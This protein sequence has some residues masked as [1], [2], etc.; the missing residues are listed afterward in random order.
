M[1][2]GLRG[3]VAIAMVLAASVAHGSNQWILGSNYGTITPG[4]IVNAYANT[5]G[6]DND[7]NIANNASLQTIETALWN[8]GYGGVKNQDAPGTSAGTHNVNGTGT[9]EG[10][11]SN[12]RWRSS[13]CDA[14]EG[15][16]PEHAIDNNQRYDMVLLS[17]AAPVRLE[18]VKLGWMQ[19][20]SD[21]TVMAFDKNRTF[22]SLI[23]NTFG[24]LLSSGWQ[25]VG[26]YFNVGTTNA[27]TVNG[28]GIASSYWLIGAYNPL[29]YY[30]TTTNSVTP[31]GDQGF[32]YVKLASVWTS[33]DTRID[34]PSG[35]PEP[36]SLALLSVALG[37]A[38]GLRR[39]S[40]S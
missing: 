11:I 30:G 10:R 7:T 1:V 40:S 31:T 16:S 38:I 3:S 32:D 26:N 25:A 24:N 20:D 15:T 36:G 28:T 18:Q 33:P 19:N 4:V 14:V 9:C 17:F 37:A 34:P 22:S 5:G 27:V 12:N 23:G 8:N 35:V 13:K 29:A 6:I 39:R 21:I 2:Y